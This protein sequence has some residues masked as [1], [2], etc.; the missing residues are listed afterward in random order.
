[1]PSMRP[2]PVLCFFPFFTPSSGSLSSCSL[3]FQLDRQQSSDQTNRPSGGLLLPS[4]PP[5]P[6]KYRAAPRFPFCWW[7]ELQIRSLEIPVHWRFGSSP[8]PW[9]T[10]SASGRRSTPQMGRCSG[11]RGRLLSSTKQAFAPLYK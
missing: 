3:L 6:L 2:R 5:S 9:R 8:A 1:L 4:S 10:R 7:A 11:R